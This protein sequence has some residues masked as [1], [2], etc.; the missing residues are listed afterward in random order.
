MKNLMIF[1][2][3]FITAISLQAQKLYDNPNPLWQAAEDDVYLQEVSQKVF[4]DSP[5]QSVAEIAGEC[6]AVMNNNIYILVDDKLNPVSSAPKSVN[7]L[8]NKSGNLWALSSSGLYKLEDDSWKLIDN[9]EFVDLTIHNGTLHGAT[10]EEIYKL[11]NDKM[12]STKPEAGYFTSN[13]TMMMADG[14]Q[15]LA[16][17]V[18]LGPISKIASYSGSMYVL[19]PGRL[20]LFDGKMVNQDFIDWGTLPSRK[21]NDMISMGSRLFISTDRG[22]SLL[23]GAA[24]TTIKGTD[25]LPYENTTSLEMGFDGDLW[26][27]TMKGAIRM[28]KDEWHYFGSNR[29]LPGNNVHDIAVGDNSVYIATDNGIGI[30]KYEPYT[31]SKK[32]KYYEQHINEWGHKRLGFVHTMFKHGNGEWVREISD[33]DGGWIA[34]ACRPSKVGTNK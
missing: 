15:V 6:Y 26:I 7:K 10:M 20:V 1:S 2:I 18:R 4:T 21:T 34:S 22:L 16:D 32:A 19:R 25:G 24:L 3:L 12:V 29:W 30:I 5:I 27:G 33:N 8:I 17:P 11:E 28:L 9:K 14:S 31:L 23:R 13:T